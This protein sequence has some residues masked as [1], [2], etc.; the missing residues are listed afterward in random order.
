MTIIASSWTHLAETMATLNFKF[1]SRIPSIER[2]FA[3]Q[4]QGLIWK[5]RYGWHVLLSRFGVWLFAESWI[6]QIAGMSPVNFIEYHL[7][8]VKIKFDKYP[9]FL[10][11]SIF[12][13]CPNF[14]IPVAMMYNILRQVS[15]VLVL[16]TSVYSSVTSISG[17][18]EILSPLPNSIYVA[19]QV[20]PVVYSF[21]SSIAATQCKYR[22]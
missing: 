18:F 10:S 16:A 12:F 13:S 8:R 14:N 21:S 5:H 11:T 19:G 4:T 20:L 3:W 22:I 6:S 9:G 1:A 15:V 17:T 2:I 7:R